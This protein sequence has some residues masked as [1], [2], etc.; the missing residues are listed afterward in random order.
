[1]LVTLDGSAPHVDPAAWVAPNAVLAGEVRLGEEASV[2]YSAVL[3]ADLGPITIGART[4]I[5]D[6]SV[7]HAD[8]GLQL[9]VGADVTVGH[10]VVL[11]GCTIHDNVLIGMGVDR[12]ERG[13][14]GSGSIVAA[15]T[16]V[17]EGM[18]IPP[19]SL[20]LGAPGKVRRETTSDEQLLIG[21]SVDGVRHDGRA[22]R[23]GMN[24]AL[25]RADLLGL[26]A[27]LA[28]RDLEL[29]PLALFEGAVAVGLDRGVVDEHVR[30]AA[31]DLDEAEALLG[32]EPLHCALCHVPVFF[33]GDVPPYQAPSGR[34]GRPSA[35]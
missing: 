26:R 22:S 10:R 12:H 3:R 4:N 17:P 16:L 7:L 33:L 24:R 1:M 9:V 30:P 14:D 20:V 6:G 25:E 23:A 19:G 8:P 27:L 13:G 11:H 5:Q 34:P 35:P 28:L 31:V 32:V 29:D 15:G 2:W 18:V 21:I